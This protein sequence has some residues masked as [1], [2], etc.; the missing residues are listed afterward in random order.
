MKKF[1]GKTIIVSAIAFSLL[2]VTSY[3]FYSYI[4]N[5]NQLK[6]EHKD[7]QNKNK[8]QKKIIHQLQTENEEKSSKI[9]QHK[10]TIEDKNKVIDE[11]EQKIEELKEKRNKLQEELQVKRD[12]VEQTSQLTTLVK[13]TSTNGGWKDFK[14]TYYD[15]NY[16]STGKYPGDTGYGKTASGRTVTEGVT[17]AVD[18]DVI[19]LGSWVLVKYPDGR[20]EKRRA[21]DTGSAINGNKIDIYVPKA[22]LS[23]GKHNVK[24]KIL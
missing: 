3:Q 18:P 10:S 24:V 21:D 20:V 16:Q 14:A 12:S 1:R 8:E 13:T 6:I 22:T 4:L 5:H 2:L 23:S 15:A 17:I 7:I 11:Q 19:P 9:E